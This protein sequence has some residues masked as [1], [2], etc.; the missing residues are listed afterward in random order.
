MYTLFAIPKPFTGHIGLIQRNAIQSWTRLEGNPEII[1]LGNEQ[2]TAEIAQKFNLRHIPNIDFTEQG[3]PLL[4]SVFG[5]ARSE[6]RFPLMAYVNADIILFSDFSRALLS[7]TKRKFLMIGQR[8]NLDVTESID[9]KNP[10]WDVELR[11]RVSQKGELFTRGGIDY[12]AFPRTLF[13]EILPLGIGRFVW[14]NWL[15]YRATLEGAYVVD[16]TKAV[17]IVHQNHGYSHSAVSNSPATLEE[18]SAMPETRRN[19][20]LVG[21]WSHMFTL[22]D[23]KWRLTEAV[24]LEKREGSQ[25]G[26]GKRFRKALALYPKTE[27]IVQSLYALVR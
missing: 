6:S 17:T 21:G 9:F 3:A 11:A 22:D 20:E 4:N 23:A 27:K 5:Q 25:I 13:S 10:I 15:V 12:F 19:L 7:L 2:G 18:L 1:L 14:D 8:W 16:A 24:Q 26:G